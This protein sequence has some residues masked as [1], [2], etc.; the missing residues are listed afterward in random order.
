MTPAPVSRY[1]QNADKKSQST[2]DR[3]S[4]IRTCTAIALERAVQD[5]FTDFMT[6]KISE[7]HA[8]QDRRIF[9]LTY[10]CIAILIVLAVVKLFV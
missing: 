3:E 8:R 2:L 1:A 9:G 10:L 6:G 7:R 5:P 4:Q